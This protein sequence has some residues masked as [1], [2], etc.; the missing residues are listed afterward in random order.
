M[1]LIPIFKN[2][3]RP[4][5]AGKKIVKLL[6]SPDSPNPITAELMADALGASDEILEPRVEIIVL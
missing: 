5:F 4:R 2:I 6:K 3:F 1:P